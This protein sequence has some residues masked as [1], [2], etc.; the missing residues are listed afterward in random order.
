M[1]NGRFRPLVRVAFA[2]TQQT[3]TYYGLVDSG[4]EQSV[5]SVAVARAAG[6][7]FDALP[8]ER[9]RG[10]GGIA[11]ARRCPID[12][13]IFGRRIGTEIF[14]VERGAILLGRHDV[15]AAFQFGFDERANTLLIE[16]YDT[17]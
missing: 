17:P 15:F 13:L 1:P 11:R 2:Y 7:D 6:V 3:K 16:P 14:V 9:I 12:L 8:A 4:A 10:I 5:C